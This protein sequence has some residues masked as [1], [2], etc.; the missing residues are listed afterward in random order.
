M[1]GRPDSCLAVDRSTGTGWSGVVSWARR[2]EPGSARRAAR[3]RRREGCAATRHRLP[4]DPGH[5]E[6]SPQPPPC[7]VR[8]AR[9]PDRAGGRAGAADAADP[10]PSSRFWSG[11]SRRL[12]RA[13]APRPSQGLGEC[14]V[15]RSRQPPRRPR[16]GSSPRQLWSG[17]QRA[18]RRF[19]D[20]FPA[21]GG[22]FARPAHGRSPAAARSRCRS[23]GGRTRLWGPQ[24]LAPTKRP[25]RLNLGNTAGRARPAGRL[26]LLVPQARSMSFA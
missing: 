13:P 14:A 19:P 9:R 11:H 18:H 16:A 8:R 1:G 3:G 5:A 21:P 12:G 24:L 23:R 26:P 15:R 7:A 25:A 4:R 10:A 22:A 17:A 20:A 2:C 6:S